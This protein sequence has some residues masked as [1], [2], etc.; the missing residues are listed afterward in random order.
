[1]NDY[2][3]LFSSSFSSPPIP[4]MPPAV[5]KVPAMPNEEEYARK[6]TKAKHEE[7]ECRNAEG[8]RRKEEEARRRV[9]EI[10]AKRKVEAEEAKRKEEARKKAAEEAK[11]KEEVEA[12]QR[13]EE[14]ERKR[15][16]E[17][18]AKAELEA[19]RKAEDKSTITV[20]K[21]SLSF[22]ADGG[23]E[24]VDINAS[25]FWQLSVFPDNWA[26]VEELTNS[27]VIEALE[28]KSGQKRADYLKIKC[29][30]KEVRVDIVQE[31]LFHS[32]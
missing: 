29:G 7:E 27:I 17:E 9:A 24:T 23:S 31:G 28:N 21:T 15:R 26:I 12:Q 10:E 11:R 19:K 13:R 18:R 22:S 16:E 30:Y 25:G 20:S 6:E 2:L 8:Q 14:K 32:K 5:P 3:R 1:M 4:G